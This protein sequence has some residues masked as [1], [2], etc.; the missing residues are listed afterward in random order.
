MQ[1]ESMLEQVK[2]MQRSLGAR[3]R[4]SAGVRLAVLGF[5]T[6][7][8]LIP[9]LMVQGVIGERRDRR[10]DAVREVSAKWGGAQTV[11]G[12]VLTIPYLD[13]FKDD[14]GNIHARRGDAHFLPDT[15]AVAGKLEVQTRYRGIYE[16]NVYRGTFA[17]SGA[18][19]SPAAMR[20]AI[21]GDE[22]LWREAF[23]SV[24]ISDMK[25]IREAVAIDLAGKGLTVS[26]G[27]RL[28]AAL[29]QGLSAA[30]PLDPQARDLPFRA[31]LDLQGSESIR[32][33][34][35]GKVTTVALSSGWGTP[36]FG[37]DFLPASREV[38]AQGFTANWKVLH[39][40]RGYP[41][42]WD[43]EEVKLGSADFGVDLLTPVDG[44]QRTMRT[45]KYAVM[46]I[47]LTFLTFFLIEVLGRRR[48]HPVQY[49]LVGAALI[50]FYTLLLSLSEHV[51]FGAGYLLAVTLT[52]SAVALYARS[53]LKSGALAGVIAALLAGLYGYLY[54]VL[55]AEDYALLLGSAGLFAAL[56][57]TMFLT[58]CLDWSNAFKRNPGDATLTG[59]S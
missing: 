33:L 7:V 27:S 23:L 55:A 49:L 43:G 41:Q 56:A 22:V 42:S 14:K 54:V 48:M 34:P 5:L 25:G 15:L 37:G 52:I 4:E 39:L 21:P 53:M 20:Q 59:C 28:E 35:L 11:G 13:H 32:F 36:S 9:A 50:I 47:S 6:L 44:Y 57:F 26:P 17:L 38:G 45:A 12:P 58:R 10:Y 24:G 51:S 46:F 3:L 16:V 31:T 1:E 18:F 29:G 19:P 8:L 2:Q 30:S 40:N